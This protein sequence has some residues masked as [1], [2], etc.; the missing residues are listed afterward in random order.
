MK[1]LIAIDSDGTLRRSDGTISN[2]TKEVIKKLKDQGHIIVIST[3]RPRYHTLKISNEVGINDYLISS[4]GT[5][6]YDNLKKEIIYSSYSDKEEVK[7]IYNEINNLSLRG[8][9]VTEDIEYTTQ[10]TR[11]DN[12][13]LLTDNNYNE[14]L[15][16]NIKQ[17]MII[18]TKKDV[19][20]EYQSKVETYN[21][22]IMDSSKQDKEEIYFSI[23]SKSSSKGNA[24]IKL[25]EYLNIPMEN[26][27]SIGNDYNDISMFK[28]TNISLAVANAD[29]ETKKYA[30]GIILGND[31]DGVRLY[32]ETL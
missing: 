29:D 17:I 26:T 21:V 25:A 30:K 10:F 23:I 15:N 8:V 9:F 28:V 3:A 27:I 32:L 19:L 14:M 2:E 20:R 5:E 18:D 13:V 22:S 31:E 7:R 11:N 4:N 16:S 1:Y 24:I 12:Q 6:V